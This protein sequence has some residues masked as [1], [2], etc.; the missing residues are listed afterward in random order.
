MKKVLLIILILALS[1]LPMAFAA[2][3]SVSQRDLLTAGYVCGEDGYELFSY[4]VFKGEEIVGEMTMKFEPLKNDSVTLPSVTEES[5]EKTFTGVNGSRLSVDLTMNNDDVIL[6]RVIYDGAFAPIYSYKRTYIGGVEKKMQVSYEGKYLHTKLFVDGKEEGGIRHKTS[7]CYDNEMLYAIVRASAVG[8]SSYS[9]SFNVVNPLTSDT[10]GI[11]ISRVGEENLS[12]KALEPTE[13]TLP[14][15]QQ[16]YKTPCYVFRIST[17]NQYASTY[18]M[19]VAKERQ[20]V[21]ND[22][23][24]IKNVKK[25]ITSITEGEYRYLLK[26]VEIA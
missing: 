7:G 13:Y 8:E 22:T 11:T 14:E 24:D 9:L 17:N 2:C 10:D 18:S 20:T 4:D 23:L 5:G 3:S 25:V 15:G 19:T 1:L 16:T 26:D 6:S 12:L 21:K